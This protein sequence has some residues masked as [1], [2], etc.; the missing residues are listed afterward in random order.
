MGSW[1]LDSALLPAG[2][3]IAES[4]EEA[5]WGGGVVAG[6]LEDA[7]LVGVRLDSTP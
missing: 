1:S 3:D 5:A 4:E 7:G 6:G 2:T